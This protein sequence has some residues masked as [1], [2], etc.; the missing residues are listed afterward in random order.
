M[1]HELWVINFFSTNFYIYTNIGQNVEQ[2]RTDNLFT[3]IREYS[4]KRHS[5]FLNYH[6]KLLHCHVGVNGTAVG[7]DLG[8][9]QT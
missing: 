6:M 3:L 9:C 7:A 8:L 1:G 2:S 4:S 5:S